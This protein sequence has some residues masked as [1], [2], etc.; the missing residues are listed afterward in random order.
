MGKIEASVRHELR[1]ASDEIIKDAVKYADPMVLRGLLYQLTGDPEVAAPTLKMERTGFYDRAVP[2]T[3]AEV[4]LLQCKAAEF[5][6]GYRDAGAGAITVGPPDRLPQSLRLIVGED[7]PDQEIAVYVEHLALNPWARALKWRTRPD[8]AERRS[9]LVF[10]DARLSAVERLH[11]VMKLESEFRGCIGIRDDLDVDAP[12]R[13]SRFLQ[14]AV[15]FCTG[16]HAHREPV[17]AAQCGG[18]R[19]V[20]PACE[21]VVSDRRVLAQQALNQIAGVVQHEHNRLESKASE[22]A[23]LLRRELMPDRRVLLITGEG[24]HHPGCL[25]S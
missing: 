18:Q 3:A 21:I 2:A 10:R 11:A 4:A 16:A 25:V 12:T 9:R 20:V 1:A 24:S 7:I 14:G 23:N 15:K 5:L 22:L 19:Q 8:Q 6:E 13:L 17:R